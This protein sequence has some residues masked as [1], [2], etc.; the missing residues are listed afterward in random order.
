MATFV[1]LKTLIADVRTACETVADLN[2]LDWAAD[3]KAYPQSKLPAWSARISESND[4]IGR[5]NAASPFWLRAVVM[6]KIVHHLKVGNDQNTTE[7]TAHDAHDAVVLAMTQP[8]TMRKYEPR[9]HRSREAL[10][11]GGQYLEQ[12]LTFHLRRL[13]TVGARTT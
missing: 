11:G 5:G 12:T 1:A 4:P 8:A 3:S 6:V 13:E 10:I 2:S 9:H 7:A